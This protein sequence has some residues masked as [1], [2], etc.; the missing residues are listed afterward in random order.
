MWLLQHGHLKVVRLLIWG[1]G[2]LERESSKRQE[3]EA[4]SLFRPKPELAQN[5]SGHMLW[6]KAGLKAVQIQEEVA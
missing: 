2:L 4:A 5:H 3:V 6:V 1:L